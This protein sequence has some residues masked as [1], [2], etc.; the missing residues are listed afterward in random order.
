MHKQRKP[1]GKPVRRSGK[2]KR[3]DVERRTRGSAS[4][5]TPAPRHQL[6]PLW[7][8]QRARLL[9]LPREPSPHV[10]RRCKCINNGSQWASTFAEGGKNKRRDVERRTRG[11]ASLP[12]PAP[13]HQLCPLWLSQSLRACSGVSR[14]TSLGFGDLISR[15]RR[16]V[17]SRS[18]ANRRRTSREGANA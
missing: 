3:R 8:S 6:C 18:R 7:L 14:R 11:S 16:T 13:R 4:L 2:K 5:P 15:W 9:A 12:T 1:M 17:G 10:Q